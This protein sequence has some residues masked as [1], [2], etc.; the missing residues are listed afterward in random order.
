MSKTF[1]IFSPRFRES[2]QPYP[3]LIT[4]TISPQLNLATKKSTH[5]AHSTL[6]P[7]RSAN[8]RQKTTVNNRNNP[9]PLTTKTTYPTMFPFRDPCRSFRCCRHSPLPPP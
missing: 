7:E 4:L 2:P 1:R 6:T 3:I 8:C 5:H 9:P